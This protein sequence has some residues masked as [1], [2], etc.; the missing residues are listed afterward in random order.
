MGGY[1][2][3]TFAQMTAYHWLANEITFMV[4]FHKKC[5]ILY[6]TQRFTFLQSNK[7]TESCYLSKWYKADL[8]SQKTLTVL[9]ERAKRPLIMELN[10]FVHISLDSL[11]AVR[12]LHLPSRL[13][14]L[15]KK[16]ISDNSLGLFTICF[17]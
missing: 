13:K 14:F 6:C 15:I 17:N 5:P 1:C 2:S 8:L 10:G 4:W 16:H 11:G 12:C 7:I 9:M 3:V